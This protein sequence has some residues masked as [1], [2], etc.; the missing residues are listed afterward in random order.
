MLDHESISLCST[1]ECERTPP[2]KGDL[3]MYYFADHFTA[4][5]IP[6]LF[7]SHQPFLQIRL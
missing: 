1:M 6:F 5:L 7:G 3:R 2:K 4:A